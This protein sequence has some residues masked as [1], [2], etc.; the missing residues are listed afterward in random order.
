V[1]VFERVFQM[2]TDLSQLAQ[3]NDYVRVTLTA[4]V[5][6]MFVSLFIDPAYIPVWQEQMAKQLNISTDRITD[7]NVTAEVID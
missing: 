4:E 6:V 7:F 1:F 5:E 2:M 3:T